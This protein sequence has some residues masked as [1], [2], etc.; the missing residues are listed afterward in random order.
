MFGHWNSS[1]ASDLT[2]LPSHILTYC[3]TY[4]LTRIIRVGIRLLLSAGVLVAGGLHGFVLGAD[5]VGKA[6]GGGVP[7]SNLT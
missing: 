4:L 7:D 5:L 6:L 1:T 2:L 3:L